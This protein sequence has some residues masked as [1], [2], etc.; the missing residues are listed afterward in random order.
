MLRTSPLLLLKCK[1]HKC[2]PRPARLPFGA[3][4]PLM[5]AGLTTGPC[6][7]LL[8]MQVGNTQLSRGELRGDITSPLPWCMQSACKA[9]WQTSPYPTHLP[10]GRGLGGRTGLVHPPRRPGPPPGQG[11]G[12]VGSSHRPVALFTTWASYLH[13]LHQCT[14]PEQSAQR[15]SSQ[16]R[17]SPFTSDNS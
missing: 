4:R 2:H 15:G 17:H 6:K 9:C 16:R 14:L 1:M 11:T 13:A 12:H 5:I 7:R 10:V 8:V 3:S